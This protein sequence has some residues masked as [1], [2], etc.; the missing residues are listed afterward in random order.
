MAE[1]T[2]LELHFEDS[3]LTA[4][5]PYSYGEKEIEAG[6]DPA[7]EDS[8]SKRGTLVAATVG[9]CFLVAVAY[10][11]RTRLLGGDEGGDGDLRA[12]L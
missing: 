7:I 1:F 10:L 5:A 8:S 6:G 9:L 2:F 4:N 3:D 11:V 12:A